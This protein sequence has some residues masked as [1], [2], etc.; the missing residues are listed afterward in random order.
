MSSRDLLH[1]VDPP[2]VLLFATEEVG[3]HPRSDDLQS[4]SRADDLSSDAKDVRIRMRSSQRRTEGILTNRRIDSANPVGNQC[5]AVANTIDE[6]PSI[7]APFADCK[8]SWIDV[9]GQVD[10]GFAIGPEI[11]NRMP[12]ALQDALNF[13]LEREARMITCQRDLHILNQISKWVGTRTL[14][15][16]GLEKCMERRHRITRSYWIC[17]VESIARLGSSTNTASTSRFS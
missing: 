3:G 5:A 9:V 1:F 13:L 6:D 7:D 8:R 15:I 17:M 11:L 2:L 14:L 16:A 12:F 10:S 4:K